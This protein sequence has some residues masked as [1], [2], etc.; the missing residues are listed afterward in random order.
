[1][2]EDPPRKVERFVVAWLLDL[3]NQFQSDPRQE[4]AFEREVAM[5][6][7]LA[8]AGADA[9]GQCRAARVEGLIAQAVHGRF[10][11]PYALGAAAARAVM[12]RFAIMF[13]GTAA[14]YEQ[15][16]ERLCRY[17]DQWPEEATP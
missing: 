16:A 9:A 12:Q 13:G 17:M 3:L 1:M 8:F 7:R 15:Q 2:P 4:Q 10:Q 11:M 6:A 5:L 14:E